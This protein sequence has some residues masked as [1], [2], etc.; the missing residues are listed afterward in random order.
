M[1][2]IV[3][4]YTIRAL[5]QWIRTK[6]LFIIC[7]GDIVPRLCF[8]GFVGSACGYGTCCR[9]YRSSGARVWKSHRTHR[10]CGHGYGSLTELTHVL[11]RY[12]YKCCTRTPVILWHGRT[13]LTKLP[14][15]GINV[16]NSRS[17]GH[18]CECRTELADFPVRVIP[19]KI[20]RV[21]FCTYPTEHNVE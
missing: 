13:E 6:P 17:S 20:P 9:T 18:G 4:H 8:V 15:T 11:G 14:G 3:H 16:Q 21:W 5:Q 12:V 7:Y 10:S 1:S 19:G 2:S